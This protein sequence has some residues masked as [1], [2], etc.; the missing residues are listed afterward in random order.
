MSF[1]SLPLGRSLCTWQRCCQVPMD[2][3][4]G[5]GFSVA[6][7]LVNITDMTMF[8][9]YKSQ[10]L[11]VNMFP[12]LFWTPKTQQNASDPLFS[13]FTK[14]KVRRLKY[15]RRSGEKSRN[16]SL[17]YIT[18]WKLL[19]TLWSSL[20]KEVRCVPKQI[21]FVSSTFFNYLTWRSQSWLNNTINFGT[22]EVVPTPEKARA[23]L[24]KSKDHRKVETFWSALFSWVSYQGE[25]WHG[26]TGAWYDW[27][28]SIVPC[29]IMY[30]A[31]QV[32][33]FYLHWASHGWSYATGA[34]LAART[35]ET[36]PGNLEQRGQD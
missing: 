16:E 26:I 17:Q 4:A 30:P 36:L 10:N 31:Q 5:G 21:S 25:Q 2:W 22:W 9:R 3:P 14:W 27:R 8:V 32:L 20:N 28:S 13:W 18:N 6:W 29:I 1:I 19:A 24:R 12:K 35:W 11:L 7:V 33:Q 23:H 34:A 15:S